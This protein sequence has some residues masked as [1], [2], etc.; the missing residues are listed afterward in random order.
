MSTSSYLFKMSLFFSILIITFSAILT[1]GGRQDGPLVVELIPTFGV[2]PDFTL[3]EAG[4]NSV[5]RTNLEGT[6]WVASFLFTSCSGT[7]PTMAVRNRILQSTLPPEVKLISI[8]V[9]PDRDTPEV[10]QKWG[11]QYER[12]PEKWLLLTGDFLHIRKLMIEGFHLQ[13]DDPFNHSNGF[14]LVDGRGFLRGYYDSLME[15][16]MSRLV[17]DTSLVLAE[18][19]LLPTSP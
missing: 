10:L 1:R 18:A 15:E 12:D 6:V 4:G 7:C 2:V 3:M 19:K 5:T 16:E 9:D 8:S 17:R 13:G 11:Q 14:A